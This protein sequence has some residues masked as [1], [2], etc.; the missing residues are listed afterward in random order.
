MPRLLLLAYGRETEYR[1]ALLAVLSCWAWRPRQ[2]LAA[3]ICT[4]QPAFFEPYLAGLP[5]A[6]KLLTPSYLTQARGPQQFV[7][8]VKAQLVAEAFAEHPH[9]GLLF[10]DSD[11]FFSASPDGLLQRLAAG[12]PFMHLREYTLAEAVAIYAEFNQ[13]QYPQKLL[14]LLASRSFALGG[15]Q[16][17]FHPGLSSWNSGVLG[18]PRAL[19]PLLP[20]IVALTDALYAGTGWF[21]SEQLAFSLAVQASGPVLA[22]DHVIYHYWGKA[23]KALMDKQLASYFTPGFAALPLARRLGQVRQRLPWFRRQLAADTAREGALYA[24]RRGRLAAGLKCAAKALLTKPLDAQFVR[25]VLRTLRRQLRLRSARQEA[26]CE[27]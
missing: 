22:S 11:T 25:A 3:T 19:A 2:P 23:Q 21:V 4:D 20:D 6:Y 13:A 15:Q 5:V 26:R 18:L 17:R 8:R 1:R 10:V 27:S 12:Q 16:V 24:L 7:H 9:D 14:E